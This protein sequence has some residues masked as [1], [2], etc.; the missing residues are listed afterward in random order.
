MGQSLN[1]QLLKGPDLTSNLVGVLTRF[2]EHPVGVVADIK[3]MYHQVCV[4]EPDRDLVRF[5]WWPYGDLSLPLKEYRMNVH[6]FGATSS[7]SCANFALRK[8]ADDGKEK[9]S[10]EVCNTVLSNFYVDDYLKSIESESKAIQLVS[11][12]TSLCKD[13]GF[14]L[15]KWLSNSREVL[16]SV[17]EDDRAETTKTLDLKNEELPSEKVLGL[18]WSPQTDRFGFHIKVKERPPTRRGILAT[19]SS[20]YDPLGFVAPAILPAKQILQNLSKLQL[21]WDES[22][23]SELLTRWE[24]WLDEVR[25]CQ[26]SPSKDV[27]SPRTL[28]KVKFRCTTSVMQVIRGMVQ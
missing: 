14:K 11:D 20:I 21:G 5:L 4:P 3:A 22:I 25:N 12:L 9:Y 8:T 27:S 15:T 6:L 24:R 26:I 18:L 10:E 28:K 13:G 19:V 17:P 1:S 2:R 23:P 7:P 16:Q